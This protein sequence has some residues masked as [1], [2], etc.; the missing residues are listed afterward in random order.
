MVPVFALEVGM[1]VRM[2]MVRARR[3]RMLVRMIM[4]RMA[5]RQILI[6]LGAA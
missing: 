1:R 3:M 4:R 5:G 2:M 6:V